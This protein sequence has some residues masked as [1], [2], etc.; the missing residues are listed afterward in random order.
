MTIDVDFTRNASRALTPSLALEPAVRLNFQAA[1]FDT[2]LAVIL[3][4]ISKGVNTA[5]RIQSYLLNR[6]CPLDGSTIAFLLR[7]HDGRDKRHCLWHRGR[8]G[9]YAALA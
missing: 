6:G 9:R 4:I 5:E 3:A 7:Q 8:N 2:I 1:D